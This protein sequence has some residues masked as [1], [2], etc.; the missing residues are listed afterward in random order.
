MESQANTKVFQP[1]YHKGGD[2]INKMLNINSNGDNLFSFDEYRNA[3]ENERVKRQTML[4][5]DNEEIVNRRELKR[6]NNLN[7]PK[8]F[9]KN[10]QLSNQVMT[11]RMKQNVSKIIRKQH[12]EIFEANNNE[13]QTARELMRLDKLNDPALF[14][15]NQQLSNQVM[16]ERT[17]QTI[18]KNIRN[19]YNEVVESRLPIKTDSS[20]RNVTK[21]NNWN[22]SNITFETS[23]N[24]SQVTRVVIRKQ[25]GDKQNELIIPNL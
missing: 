19:N 7:D 21:N 16:T 12:N 9:E 10:Q 15:H 2:Y 8:L 14:E 4:K 25:R 22:I 3:I 20:N 24:G 5:T 23:E 1:V 18:S 17:K 13:A 11:E 6:F